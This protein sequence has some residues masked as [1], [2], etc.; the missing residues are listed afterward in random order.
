MSLTAH[1]EMFFSCHALT[2]GM[3]ETKILWSNGIEGSKKQ[4]AQRVAPSQGGARW[5]REEDK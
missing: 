1:V 3:S 4:L 5:L 2:P